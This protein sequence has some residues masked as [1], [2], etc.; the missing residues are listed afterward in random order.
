MLDTNHIGSLLKNVLYILVGGFVLY[1]LFWRGWILGLILLPVVLGVGFFLY[2]K[3]K[4][5]KAGIRSSKA[6]EERPDRPER[7]E[8]PAETPRND[9]AP[10]IDD[11]RIQVTD[12][13]D[14]KEVEFE[15]E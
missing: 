8:R 12:L 3:V 9:D 7:P 1:L 2:V 13:S 6:K 5:L 10:I 4:E 14:A 11:G 15:K